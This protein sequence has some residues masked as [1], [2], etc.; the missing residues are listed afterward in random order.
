MCWELEI[1][2]VYTSVCTPVL[3][4]WTCVMRHVVGGAGGA[5]TGVVEGDSLSSSSALSTSSSLQDEDKLL[6]HLRHFDWLQPHRT[7]GK[8]AQRATPLATVAHHSGPGCGLESSSDRLATAFPGPGDIPR[9]PP[10]WAGCPNAC[11][12]FGVRFSHYQPRKQPDALNPN[13]CISALREMVN[14]LP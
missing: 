10:V 12:T 6:S 1:E 4:M 7:T 8:Q 11:C 5:E 2:S 14:A 9:T 3:Q 13:R